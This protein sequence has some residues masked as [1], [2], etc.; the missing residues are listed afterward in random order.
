M[1][2][3]TMCIDITLNYRYS[4]YSDFILVI[5]VPIIIIIIIIIMQ[6]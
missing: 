2:D 1:W 3:V 5:N 4:Y 6:Y